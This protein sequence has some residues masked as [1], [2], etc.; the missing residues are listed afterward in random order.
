MSGTCLIIPCTLKADVFLIAQF[1]GSQGTEVGCGS[2]KRVRPAPDGSYSPTL[3][4]HAS[5]NASL[6]ASFVLLFL[7]T[8]CLIELSHYLAPNY[9]SVYERF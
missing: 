4:L 9:G 2:Q 8:E 3:N 1:V 6:H 5:Q 7:I